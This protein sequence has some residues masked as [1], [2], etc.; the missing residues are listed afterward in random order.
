ME[1]IHT[2]HAKKVAAGLLAKQ[3]P[4]RQGPAKKNAHSLQEIQTIYLQPQCTLF[5]QQHLIHIKTQVVR[6]LFEEKASDV[7]VKMVPLMK[8]L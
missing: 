3:H 7:V 6:Q 4:P 8:Q 2:C 1:V 5:A